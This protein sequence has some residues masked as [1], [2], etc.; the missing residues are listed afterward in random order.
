MLKR[1]PVSQVRLGMHIQALEGAWIDHPFWQTRFVLE[2]VTDL[3]K[4]QESQVPAVVIDVSKGLDV[5]DPAEAEVPAERSPQPSPVAAPA[6]AVAP[7]ARAASAAPPA[8]DRSLAEELHQ[9]QAICA[10]A[11]EQV[12]S[13]FAEA[14][15]G[16]AL[17]AEQCLPLVKEIADSVFR[18]PGA[19]VSLARLK[20]QDDYTYMHSVAVCALM[21]SLARQLELS[22]AQC[23]AAGLAGLLHD[24]GK[25]VMPLEV[26]NKPGK[27]TDD[28]FT[29]MK[30]HPVRGYEMLQEAH[31]APEA[32]M[33][34]CLHHHERIDGTGYPHRLAGEQI[35]LL[36]RMGAVCDV[37]DAITSNRPYKAGWD[38]ASSVAKMASWKG[39]FDPRIFQAFV[40]SLGI[41][42]VGSLVRLQSGR[43]AVVTEQNPQSL[44]SPIVKAFFSVNAQMPMT[45]VVV[46]LSQSSDQIV[47]RENPKLWGFK[48]LDRLWAGEFLPY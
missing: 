39:H 23:R 40:K 13:M 29:I 46:D 21:V 8:P 34:V 10:E 36:A 12:T 26:L 17:D 35:S 27:L 47:S 15:L 4:L 45:P 11:R 22:E 41:Y 30:S 6:P 38:P 44:V 33:D 14:R 18:N 25:A 28:E 16:K 48:D 31:G 3:R 43:L 32:A 7:T 20:T 42:P 19:L 37:Y 9:A 5:L 2:D 24:L 1:I